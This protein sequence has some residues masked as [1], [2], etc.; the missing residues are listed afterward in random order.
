MTA[1]I[2]TSKLDFNKLKSSL[3]LTENRK[4]YN[5]FRKKIRPDTV[6][7]IDCSV[8]TPETLNFPSHI[9]SNNGMFNDPQGTLYL[10]PHLYL[11][12]QYRKDDYLP[13]EFREL[14]I[15]QWKEV[16]ANMKSTLDSHYARTGKKVNI[17]RTRLIIQ[18]PYWF[19][20]YH[21]HFADYTFTFCYQY[22]F[23]Q[24]NLTFIRVHHQHEDGE[25]SPD[26][27]DVNYPQKEKI[28]FSFKGDPWH[29]TLSNSWNFHWIH[30]LD[31]ELTFPETIGEFASHNPKDFDN[32]NLPKTR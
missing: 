17:I 22:R 4:A 32:D 1:N 16:N 12:L 24:P 8:P 23:V 25:R 14:I 21:R 29:C 2:D 9:K 15:E 6:T 5:P 3:F 30:D 31:D 26:Y 7:L 19:L 10:M 20:G 27:V 18:E 11:Q 28:F 13:N